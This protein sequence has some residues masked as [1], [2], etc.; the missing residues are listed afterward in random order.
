MLIILDH[1]YQPSPADVALTVNLPPVL[2]EIPQ[3]GSLEGTNLAIPG[4][5]LAFVVE[6]SYVILQIDKIIKAL[7][8]LSTREFSLSLCVNV[9][10]MTSQIFPRLEISPAFNTEELL[11]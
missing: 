5:R 1:F 10:N 6:E 7:I 8:T 11:P 3:S 2:V 9:G 4:F